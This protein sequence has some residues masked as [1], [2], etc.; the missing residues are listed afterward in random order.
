MAVRYQADGR[1]V[2]ITLDRPEALNSLD[3]D[4]WA[5]FG[6]STQRFED[7]SS[8][9]VAIITGA[10]EKAFCA[11]ADIKS[12]IACL[13]DDPRA[14]PYAS[15]PTIMR[16][17]RITKPLIAAIN[18][19]AMGGGLEVALACDIRIAVE[20]VRLGAPEVTLGLIPGWGGTQRLSRQVTWAI[21]SQL[22]LTG[23]PIT[24]E[25][26]LQFGLVNAI[27]PRDQLMGEARNWAEKLVRAGPLAVRAAK[28]AMLDGTSAG[29]EEGLAIE[30]RLFDTMAYTADLREGLAAFAEKRKAEFGGH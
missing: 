8:V 6:E 9:W 12:T 2:T 22:V 28:Q 16:G 25:Q 23:Q 19:V 18:G 1:I 20:G 7:D 30:Q 26:A 14:N 17:Q 10:G 5:A 3:L 27:V 29:L 11:G 4:T 15:P 24:A 13:M 21:A